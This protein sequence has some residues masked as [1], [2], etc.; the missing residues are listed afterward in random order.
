MAHIVLAGDSIF[1]NAAYVAKSQAVIDLL[2]QKSQEKFKSTLIAVDGSVT[3][4]LD[5]Q[6]NRLPADA[7]HLF[8]SSGGND[9]LESAYLLREP[10]ST[11]FE[12]MTVFSGVIENFQSQYRKMLQKAVS[13]TDKVAVCTIYDSIPG[14]GKEPMV[15][16]K[17]FNEVI[18]REAF[19]FGLPVVDLRLICDD[20]ADYSSVSP[21]EPSEQ[22]GDKISDA[23]TRMVAQHDFLNKRSVVWQ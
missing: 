17:L 8:I 23:I 21:I 18:L 20:P 9:A 6:L 15:A 1:D 19:N 11:V 2:N 7:T 4:D 5:Y 12:A 13:L 3:G 16:L 22:G 10:V 14:Y